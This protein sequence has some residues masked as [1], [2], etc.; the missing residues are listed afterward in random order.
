KS[1]PPEREYTV[2]HFQPELLYRPPREASH[3]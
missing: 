3:L 2:L 1:I